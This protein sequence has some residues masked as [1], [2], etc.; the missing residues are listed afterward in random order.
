MADHSDVL[1]FSTIIVQYTFRKNGKKIDKRPLKVRKMAKFAQKQDHS[2]EI[3]W[4]I[5][6]ENIFRTFDTDGNGY[7]TKSELAQV[8]KAM[9]ETMTSDDIDDMV[10]HKT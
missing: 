4:Q 2:I 9:G 7:I 3:L 6:S 10:S 5:A 8:M 1:Q